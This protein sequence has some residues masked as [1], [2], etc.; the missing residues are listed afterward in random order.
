[1]AVGLRYVVSLLVLLSE[2][3]ML[4]LF[5]DVYRRERERREPDRES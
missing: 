2:N 3:R 4:F 1:M 5:E